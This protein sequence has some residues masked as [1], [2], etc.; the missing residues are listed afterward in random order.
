[1]ISF[2]ATS[3]SFPLLTYL[4]FDSTGQNVSLDSAYH[5]LNRTILYQMSRPLARLTGKDIEQYEGKQNWFASCDCVV[6]RLNL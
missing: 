3:Y 2:L 6:E 1:M 4:S 5:S